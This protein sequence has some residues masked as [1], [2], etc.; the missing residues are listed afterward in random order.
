MKWSS[1]IMSMLM[2]LT[3]RLHFALSALQQLGHIFDAL[4]VFFVRDLRHF[5]L[6]SFIGNGTNVTE[7]TTEYVTTERKQ[8][9]SKH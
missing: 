6:M 2:E 1:T 3:V 7:A 5:Q 9:N 8:M 4:V